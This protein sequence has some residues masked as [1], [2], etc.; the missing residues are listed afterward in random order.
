MQLSVAHNEHMNLRALIG[1]GIVIYATLYLVWSALAI[2]NLSGNF[3]SRIVIFA[4]L[5]T[6][7]AIAT[8]ALRLSTERD[9]A[10]F[11][12]GWVVVAMLL[13]A[14][15]VVPGAGW[16]IYTNWNLW[17]GYVLLLLVPLIVIAVSKKSVTP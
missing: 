10:P 7:A 15:I 11:A 12:I 14:I 16:A 13:D 2:H 4:T 5:I 17:V 3:L 1:W 8:R 6:V 9:V